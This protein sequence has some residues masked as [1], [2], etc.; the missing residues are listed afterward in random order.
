M[1]ISELPRISMGRPKKY[2]DDDDKK[3]RVKQYN[4]TYYH[5]HKE[6]FSGYIDCAICKC[7]ISKSNKSRHNKSERHLNNIEK[8]IK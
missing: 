7:M 2:S 4:Q 5:S 8:L 6:K 3:E 1:E